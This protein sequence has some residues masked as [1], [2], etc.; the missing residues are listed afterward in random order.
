MESGHPLLP[1]VNLLGTFELFLGDLE[2]AVPPLR[3][4][5]AEKAGLITFVTGRPDLLDLDQKRVA[6]AIEGNVLDSL[7]VAAGFAFHPELLTG[8]APEMSFAGLQGFFQRA[9]VHPGHHQ[10]AAGFVFLDDG[11]NQPLA[12]NFNWSKKL[13]NCA[14]L[15]GNLADHQ[16]ATRKMSL[17]QYE[18]E[19]QTGDAGQDG[20]RYAVFGVIPKTDLGV[21]PGGLHHDNISD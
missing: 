16:E 10:D 7:R 3:L 18:Q 11:R 13:I 5:R 15:P 17:T 1:A 12:S 20:Y 14:H 4:N 8:T 19:E 9:A 2:P 6:V 21:R